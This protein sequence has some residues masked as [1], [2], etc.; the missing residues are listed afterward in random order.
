[1]VGD[2]QLISDF[3]QRLK[4]RFD[5]SDLG[6]IKSCIGIQIYHSQDQGK[7][8]PHQSRFLEELLKKT[9]MEH[10]NNVPTPALEGM[11]LSKNKSP[12]TTDDHRSVRLLEEKLPYRPTV[13][14]LLW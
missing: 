14:S 5:I 3:K 9:T 6:E 12:S 2:K 8:F 1:M 7:M 11:K 10:A 13:S 4:R